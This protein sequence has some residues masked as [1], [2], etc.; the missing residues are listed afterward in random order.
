MRIASPNSSSSETEA[1]CHPTTPE[2]IDASLSRF[3]GAQAL[4]QHAE[5]LEDALESVSDVA[6]PLRSEDDLHSDATL[7][8]QLTNQDPEIQKTAS[9][10][11]AQAIRASL[12]EETAVM[13]DKES[14]MQVAEAVDSKDTSST[15][16]TPAT[17]EESLKSD[18]YHSMSINDLEMHNATSFLAAQATKV[19][20]S[21]KDTA[22]ESLAQVPEAVHNKD[23]SSPSTTAAASAEETLRSIKGSSMSITELEI[24]KAASFLAAQAIRESLLEETAVMLAMQRHFQ[25]SEAVQNKDVNLNELR[26]VR[27]E[28]ENAKSKSL[29]AEENPR[30]SEEP[31]LT[32]KL[33]VQE[34]ESAELDVQVAEIGT[35]IHAADSVNDGHR[36]NEVVTGKPNVKV[37]FISKETERQESHEELLV[38]GTATPVPKVSS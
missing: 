24:Q 38:R 4:S 1:K 16:T 17:A 10:L 11:V 22:T 5:A 25:V 19:S 20:L 27:P 31:S 32:T 29:G 18:K 28:V 30:N 9:F 12:A 36:G 3:S 8:P 13:L 34:K 26:T 15:S 6:Q 21:S 33:H 2:V 37:D 35:E 14:H 23:A 7:R